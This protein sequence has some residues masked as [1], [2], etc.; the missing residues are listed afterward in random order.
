[1]RN[2]V[3]SAFAS[4]ALFAACSASGAEKAPL[5]FE[6]QEID[7]SLTVGYAV[8]VVDLNADGKPDVLVCD[9]N[10]VI[11]FSGGDWKMHTVIENAKAG[12]KADNVCIDTY[13]IDGDGR[14][15]IALGAD[16]VPANTKS[17][18]S[19]QWLKQPA[20]ID[21]PWSVHKIRESDPT[22][23][24]IYFAELTGDDR[25][26]LVVAPL[27][28]A[29]STDKAGAENGVQLSAYKIP[30]DPVKG[31]WERVVLTEQFH[32][33]HNLFPVQWGLSQPQ[34]LLIASYEGVNLLVPD[35]NSTF[36]TYPLGA[37]A[38]PRADGNRGSSE[39]R[40]GRLKD[41]RKILATVEPFHGNQAVVYVEP[42]PADANKPWPRTVLDD[43]LTGGHSVA[44]ADLDG[45]GND[46]VVIGWRDV[47]AGK[48][49]TGIRV[50]RTTGDGTE[51]EVAWSM[52][53]IEKGDM[54]AEDLACADLNGDGKV[55]IV[56]V[57]RKTKN[58]KIYWNKTPTAAKP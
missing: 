52:Q 42:K 3:L 26:E 27:K 48:P 55:D 29:G 5:V 7:K 14:L 25:K 1:M 15:D 51:K 53:Q 39:I 30:A 11:W 34:Q 47:L 50:F 20:D 23:H 41:G 24:R 16:W 10:R 44:C 2:R 9:A 17:A 31:P 8:R 21:Q 43:T 19:L 18:G 57:G 46:E 49:P 38:P 12:V 33:M 35:A 40:P 32:I 13:D 36:K 58:V 6:A 56:A 45:D 54:A 4:F 28:G 37:G 22:L